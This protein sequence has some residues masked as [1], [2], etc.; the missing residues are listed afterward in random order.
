MF[1][2]VQ[3]LNNWLHGGSRPF[4][5]IDPFGLPNPGCSRAR[6]EPLDLRADALRPEVL[7]LMEEVA[8]DLPGPGPGP[9]PH[10]LAPPGGVD[11]GFLVSPFLA[12]YDDKSFGKK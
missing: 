3:A 7:Q 5:A 1:F 2:F 8:A 6:S 12:R 11:G 10:G 9:G 4:R